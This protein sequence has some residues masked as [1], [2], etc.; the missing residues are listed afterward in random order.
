MNKQEFLERL[1]DPTKFALRNAITEFKEAHG[2]MLEDVIWWQKDPK[3]LHGND[4]TEWHLELVAKEIGPVLVLTDIF[5]NY[6][7]DE[8]P[9]AKIN[10]ETHVI[11]DNGL[12]IRKF[13]LAV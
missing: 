4:F 8:L 10:M 2:H 13:G 7:L 1:K 12:H 5:A 6:I 11:E 3:L 9:N